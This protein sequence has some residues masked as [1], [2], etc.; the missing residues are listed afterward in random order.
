M[1]TD[2]IATI[3]RGYRSPSFG[4]ASRNFYVSFLAALT[5]DRNPDK[6]FGNLK[7]NPQMA[8]TEVEMPAYVPLDA[9]QRALQVDRSKLVALNPAL[10]PPVWNGSQFVPKGYRLRLPVEAKSWT[11]ASLGQQLDPMDQYV[12]QPRERSYRAKSGDTLATVARR[13]GLSIKVLA[14]LNGMDEDE[15]LRRRQTLRLPGV[16]ATRITPANGGAGSVVAATA[17]QPETAKVAAKVSETLAVQRA[18]TR[19]VAKQQQDPQ[20]VT[21]AEAQADSPSLVPGGAVASSTES[22]DYGIGTDNS[23]HV[24]AEETIGHYAQWLN[25]S[26]SH[27]RA[28]NRLGAAAAVPLGR[29]LKLDFSKTPREQFDARRREFHDAMQATFFAA[30]RITGTQVYVTRRGDSLWAVS[31]RHGGLPAWLVLHYNPDIDFNALRAGLEI[32]IPKVE[33]QPVT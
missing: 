12:N 25:V 22:V 19:A 6:Y 13:N 5:I 11:V 8:F 28:L 3:V 18:E 15:A 23:I 9:L 24:A 27:L 4:F 29:R 16:P 2:N 31:Q 7:R 10:R 14:R 26:A 30:H 33:A 17:A 32:V 1:G 21:A 20:P